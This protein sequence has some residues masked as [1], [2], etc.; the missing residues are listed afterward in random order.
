MQKVENPQVAEN[1]RT[2][3]LQFVFTISKWLIPIVDLH[4]YNLNGQVRS[5]QV[6]LRSTAPICKQ[7][8]YLLTIGMLL[9]NLI[10][11]VRLG[12]GRQPV[13]YRFGLC[14][15]AINVQGPAL[16]AYNCWLTHYQVAYPLPTNQHR[17]CLSQSLKST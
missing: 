2:F 1:L 5:G 12:Y 15:D 4:T 7:F 9:S 6:S 3:N 11:Y 14:Q 8:A 13:I 17:F 16:A 10:V